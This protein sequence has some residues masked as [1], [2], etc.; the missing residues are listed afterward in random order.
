M[1]LTPKPG[2]VLHIALHRWQKQR[3]PNRHTQIEIRVLECPNACLT[4]YLKDLSHRKENR[5]S[6]QRYIH[7]LRSRRVMVILCMFTC[8]RESTPNALSQ[9]T[10]HSHRP[11]PP[12][13]TTTASINI[14]QALVGIPPAR[15]AQANAKEKHVH[16]RAP[17]TEVAEKL[18]PHLVLQASSVERPSAAHVGTT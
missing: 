4:P 12:W 11:N 1:E 14:Y 13:G 7:Q 5:Q 3:R 8:Q 2:A 6:Q 9:T 10:T 17:F 16:E 15:V 18:L